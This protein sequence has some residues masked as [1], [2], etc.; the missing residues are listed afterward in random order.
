MA[1]AFLRDPYWPFRAAKELGAEIE[2]P[3]QYR[4]AKA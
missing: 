1:R 2:W 3:A 4:R